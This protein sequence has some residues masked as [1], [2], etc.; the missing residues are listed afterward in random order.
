MPLPP[1]SAPPAASSRRAELFDNLSP[2]ESLAAHMRRG[3]REEVT[4]DTCRYRCVADA[5]LPCSTGGY[6]RIGVSI[7]RRRWNRFI[8]DE[9]IAMGNARAFQASGLGDS[10][11][12]VLRQPISRRPQRRTDCSEL[13]ERLSRRWKLDA[14]GMDAVV[15]WQRLSDAAHS[16]PAECHASPEVKV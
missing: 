10:S 1:P 16:S 15:A 14:S 7:R 5:P 3:P 8:G 4:S 13:A 9:T 6:R 2:G 11:L 12:A